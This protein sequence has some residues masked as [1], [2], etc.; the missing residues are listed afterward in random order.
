VKLE[1]S[2]PTPQGRTLVQMLWEKLDEAVDRLHDNGEPDPLPQSM[3]PRVVAKWGTE[4]LAWGEERGQA[5]GLALAIAVITDPYSPNIDA[6]R[7]VSVE[8][9]KAREKDA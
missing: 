6:V 1:D 9:R 8:R 5:Q 7:K 4:T 3:N 2:F